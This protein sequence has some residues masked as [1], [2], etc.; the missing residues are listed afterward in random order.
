M[1]NT[2]VFFETMDESGEAIFLPKSHLAFEMCD[3]RTS[4]GEIELQ[5]LRYELRNTRFKIEVVYE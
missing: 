5:E 3:G 2:L 4:L 1:D